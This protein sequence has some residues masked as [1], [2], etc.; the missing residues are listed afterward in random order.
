MLT[1]CSNRET[2]SSTN[3]NCFARREIR[4]KDG[5]LKSASVRHAGLVPEIE[6]LQTDPNN[7]DDEVRSLQK[8]WIL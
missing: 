7:T 4:A 6:V 1:V 2:S 8:H 3:R 5:A